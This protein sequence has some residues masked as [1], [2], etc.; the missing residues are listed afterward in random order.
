M[1]MNRGIIL[2]AA[3]HP[4]YGR[5][6]YNLALSLKSTAPD[7]P[8]ALFY[9]GSGISHFNDGMKSVFDSISEIPT[10]YIT[11]KGLTEYIKAKTAL[12][13]LSPFDETI[14]LDVDMI[15]LPQRSIYQ[16]FNQ[17]K[18]VYFTIKTRGSVS[19]SDTIKPDHSWWANIEEV[20]SAYGFTSGKW[21][22]LSSEFIYFKKGK[23]QKKFFDTAK[24]IYD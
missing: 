5:Y 18:D 7:L 11:R 10:K 4:F 23:A 16:I 9:S 15:W 24:K 19:L 8:I 2:I 21:L 14:Y 17:L 22:T 13:D 6:A 20:K 3:G 12:Y 1:N